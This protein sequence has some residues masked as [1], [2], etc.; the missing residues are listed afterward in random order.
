[1]ALATFTS[2]GFVSVFSAA[3]GATLATSGFFVTTGFSATGFWLSALTTPTFSVRAAAGFAAGT[4]LPALSVLAFGDAQPNRPQIVTLRKNTN[5]VFF[6][7]PPI[8][9]EGASRSP[10]AASTNASASRPMKIKIL[11]GF[12][13]MLP[14]NQLRRL[15]HEQRNPE[16]ER[17]NSDGRH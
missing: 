7:S 9:A 1:M 16:G 15:A 3:L 6:I 11:C 10:K 2:T 8:E 14:G 17:Q 5:P 12:R 4:L 13:C